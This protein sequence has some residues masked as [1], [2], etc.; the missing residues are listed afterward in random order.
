MAADFFYQES[1]VENHPFSP[2]N[3][4]LYNFWLRALLTR[5]VITFRDGTL[6]FYRWLQTPRLYVQHH[7]KQAYEREMLQ[8]QFANIC[9]ELVKTLSRELDYS[10]APIIIAQQA[11]EDFER[12]GACFSGIQ[13]GYYFLYWSRILYRLGNPQR[14]LELLEH[15]REIAQGQD[16]HLELLASNY[17]AYMRMTVGQQQLSLALLEQI[18]PS[19]RKLG[20]RDR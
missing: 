19:M 18:L 12:G 11:Y 8:E 14:A 16:Q 5:K 1:E 6:E 13:Q 7:L 20:H 4:S 2:R 3:D 15:V 17:I 9:F 10:G